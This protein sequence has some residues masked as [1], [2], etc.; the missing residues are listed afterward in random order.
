[1]SQTSALAGTD[2]QLEKWVT[3]F[4][5]LGII[6]APLNSTMIAVALPGI[7]DDFR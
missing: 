2:R 4:V 6:F 5:A 3:M 7:L 1:V